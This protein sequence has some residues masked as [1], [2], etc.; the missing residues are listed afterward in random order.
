MPA[1]WRDSNVGGC[2]HSYLLR[3]KQICLFTE[4]RLF[5]AIGGVRRLRHATAVV[6]AYITHDVHQLV[7]DVI[8]AL[9]FA[10][11]L[12]STPRVDGSMLAVAQ[13]GTPTDT[14][15]GTG[16]RDVDLSGA[17][18]DPFN[19]LPSSSVLELAHTRKCLLNYYCT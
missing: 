9:F 12:P 14:I 19:S 17:D 16:R 11:L 1:S 18:I 10:L 7:F 4:L 5:S 8:R 15:V 2:R 3:R 6:A 13:G